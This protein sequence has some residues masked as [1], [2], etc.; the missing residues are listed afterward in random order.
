[1]S[2]S[3]DNQNQSASVISLS[4]AESAP[5][6]SKA[7][8]LSK[9]AMGG[10][11]SPRCKSRPNHLSFCDEHYDQFKFGLIKMTGEPVP[12]YEKKVDHYQ[13][14]KLHRLPKAA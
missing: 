6:G 5:R 14:Y 3:K 13:N 7:G 12:D 10:C 4:R 1:M 9:D 8:S 2:K 11:L